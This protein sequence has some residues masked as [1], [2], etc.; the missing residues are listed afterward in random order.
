MI[1]YE[2]AIDYYALVGTIAGHNPNLSEAEMCDLAVVIIN[3][4]YR[5]TEGN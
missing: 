4:G 1:P 5:L 2:L 3:A